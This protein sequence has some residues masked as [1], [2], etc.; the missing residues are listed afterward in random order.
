MSITIRPS[1]AAD[2]C[3]L[4]GQPNPFRTRA[5]SGFDESGRLLGAGGAHFLPD[6]TVVAWLVLDDDVEPQRF[7]KTLHRTATR[8]LDQMRALGFR[9]IVAFPEE[10]VVAAERWLRRLGFKQ[11]ESDRMRIFVRD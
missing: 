7:A 8:F 11:V 2:L 3:R 6:G 10:G 1:T 9:R 5:L 4:F